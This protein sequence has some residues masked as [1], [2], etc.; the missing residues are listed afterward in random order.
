MKTVILGN[1][2][3]GKTWLAERLSKFHSVPVVHL[4]SKLH[5]LRQALKPRM[6]R[7]DIR[8]LFLV[9]SVTAMWRP[10]LAAAADAASAPAANTVHA[11]VAAYVRAAA[12]G[13]EP[14]APWLS[15][16]EGSPAL[17]RVFGV[18]LGLG[19]G[20]RQ[21]R[22]FVLERQAGGGLRELARSKLFDFFDASGRTDFEIIEAQSERR[23]S[24][25]INA[26]SACGVHVTIYRFAQLDA[27]D[28]VLSGMDTRTP[29][30][31][32]TGELE[33]ASTRS[34]NF[35]TGKRIDHAYRHDKPGKPS[36]RQLTFPP[37]P[38]AE[39]EP[40]DSRHEL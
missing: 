18:A 5:P 27:G 6:C 19:E 25:Q 29:R 26:R 36:T 39:F 11:S 10:G 12:G 20:R 28:W 3:S 14:D 38:L 15:T 16:E 4:D 34:T 9:L 35:L 17:R 33:T 32:R 31:G 2:G 8:R 24:L 22:V 40:F 7:P 30:C 13:R 1:S 23:F 21:A 37:F